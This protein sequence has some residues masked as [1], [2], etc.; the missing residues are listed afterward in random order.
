M[1]RSPRKP[2]GF[3]RGPR[4]AD[5]MTRDYLAFAESARAA[6]CTG[7]AATALEYHQGV[8]MF[9]RGAHRI[10]LAQLADLAEEMTPWLWARW[11]AYQCTRYEETGTRAG[12][13]NRFAGEYTVRMFHAERMGQAYVDGEDPVPF[14]AQVAG[15]DW[16]F[17]QLCTYEFGGL[18][19]Y[20]D[21]V[22]AGRLA[23]ES[24]LA[25]EWVRARMGAYRF[26]SSGPGGLVV[27]ELVSGC[28]RTLL[29]LGGCSGIE[30]GGF[31][32]GRLV[33]SGTTPALMF[34]TRPM[35]VDEETARET[36]AGTERGA[37]VAALDHAFRDD[38]LDRSILL[39]E[40]RE[41]VTDVPSLEL[42]KRF[43]APSALASTMAQL[44]AGRDEIGRAAYRIL[45]RAAEGTL[46]DNDM[47]AYV[48]AAVVNPAGFAEARRQLVD[49]RHASAW[50]RWAALVPEP[51]R[52]RLELL[53]E[54]S[55]SRAA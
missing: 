3:G 2:L 52:G 54:L 30:P 48:A 12:E 50:E 29:D 55:E 11:A 34:D 16:A 44:A 31:V 32:L 15:E 25:R 23:E 8:P 33:P 1:S 51:A 46:G 24:V 28:T 43:T 4:I 21:T 35:P 36:A 49:P 37:W 17:H 19:A 38:R 18:E 22:A 41:L 40:D 27:R 47:A 5:L 53:A 45:R 26:E 10:Q 6:E 39:R 20:L 42:V 13:V 7:D 14:L 9:V